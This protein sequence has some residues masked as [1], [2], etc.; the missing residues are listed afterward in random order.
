ML[1]LYKNKIQLSN[2]I[3]H[4]IKNHNIR[5][6]SI[7]FPIAKDSKCINN[8]NHNHNH[9]VS[10]SDI[11]KSIHSNINATL[12]HLTVVLSLFGDSNVGVFTAERESAMAQRDLC[13]LGLALGK[14]SN[15]YQEKT[16]AQ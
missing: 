10:H 3:H 15:R 4:I 2:K 11:K 5:L 16:A 12:G 9:N 1:P 6:I 13:S 8:Y 7:S 14:V